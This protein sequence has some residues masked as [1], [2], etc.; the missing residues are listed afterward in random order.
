[1]PAINGHNAEKGNIVRDPKPSNMHGGGR[2][3]I[4]H[5]LT[6]AL[7][8]EEWLALRPGRFTRGNKPGAHGTGGLG[9]AQL[10]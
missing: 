10:V 7:D 6:S 5:A 8:E 9:G 4:A 2:G 3:G 1:L